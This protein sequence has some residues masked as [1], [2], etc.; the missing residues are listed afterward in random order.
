MSDY[1]TDFQAKL[2]KRSDIFIAIGII[3]IL[4]VMLFP[5]HPTVIDLLLVFNFML[6]FIIL[7]AP[8]Y[9]KRPSDFSVFPGLLLVVTL[10]RLAMNVATTRLILGEADAGHIIRAFGTFMIRGNY[11]VGLIVFLILFIINFKVIVAGSGRVAEVAARFTLDAMPGKQMAVDADLNNGVISEDEAKARREE[12][13]RDGDFYGAMDGAAKFVKGDALAGIIIMVLNILGGILIGMVQRKMGFVQAVQTYTI[14]TVG[15]GLVA[16][17]PSL[18]ISSATGIIVTRAGTKADLGEEVVTQLLNEPKA[19]F[20]ASGVIFLFGL[21]PGMPWYFFMPMGAGLATLAWYL[22]RSIR[23]RQQQEEAELAAPPEPES[24]PPDIREYLQVDPLELE[25]GYSLISLVD[26]N[27]KGDILD[28]V[29]SL[30]K[31]T[32]LDVG[33]LVPPIRIRDNISLVPNQYV[34]KIRG[35]QIAVGECLV[36][37][38][39]AIDPGSVEKPIKGIKTREPAFGLPAL[40]ITEDKRDIA[41]M[42]GYT[43][44]EPAAMIATHL[45]E[46]IKQ[47]AGII[48]TR[49]DVQNLL[50][51][52]KKDNEAVVSELVPGLLSLGNVE[53]VLKNLLREGVAVRDMIT[54]LET[55]ADYAPFTRDVETLTEYVR[56]AL[57]RTIAK[58]FT[59][60]DGTVYGVTLSP[61]FEQLISDVVNQ[62][63]Q[64][65]LNVSVPPDVVNNLYIDLE[66]AVSQMN[67]LGL[68]PV[69]MV[70]PAIRGYMKKLIEPAIPSLPIISF[71]EIPSHIP[72][73]SKVT[74]QLKM[75]RAASESG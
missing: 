11:I 60:S 61:Q 48:I 20:V 12:I 54:I 21:F 39:L 33:I 69:V 67:E 55:L 25:I 70:S 73:Q 64:K 66:K 42:H 49:Q 40:W 26:E 50:D 46:V 5:M 41:E 19:L 27:E 9:L 17:I 43:I 47:N 24:G 8:I 15:D 35:E 28:R 53:Q 44:I 51:N 3:S 68:Q 56:Y 38:Y 71:N 1:K 75:P 59:A 58:K 74:L 37:H 6:A 34:I 13:R 22:Q 36:N 30:R 23:D 72:I 45:S 32:A 57:A 65:K 63:K 31:Q 29:T 18:L 7:L 16:Q 62:G 2:A 14:L 4:V 10:F 52:I